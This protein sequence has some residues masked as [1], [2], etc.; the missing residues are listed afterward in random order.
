MVR[1]L[2]WNEHL[3]ERRSEDVRRIYPQGIHGC[4]A[5]TLRIQSFEVRTATLEEPQHGLSPETLDWAE[6]VLWWGHLAHAQVD[7]SAVSRVHARV[8]EGMGL[9][10]LHSAHYSKI[11]KRLLGTNCSLTW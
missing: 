3:H 9:V 4:I 1:V 11:L 8:L 6:V 7:D 2:V 10:A 5:A